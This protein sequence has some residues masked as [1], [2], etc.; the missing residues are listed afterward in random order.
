MSVIPTVVRFEALS[1]NDRILCTYRDH[2]RYL[3]G[4]IKVMELVD[5]IRNIEVETLNLINPETPVDYEMDRS[6]TLI[7]ALKEIRNR[8]EAQLE[9]LKLE[10]G[11]L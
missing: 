1:N 2:S 4:S 9:D 8:R 11:L 3:E 10:R 5:E 7:S 6:T